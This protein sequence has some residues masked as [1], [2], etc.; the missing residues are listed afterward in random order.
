MVCQLSCYSQMR[1]LKWASLILLSPSRRTLQERTLFLAYFKSVSIFFSSS[2][3]PTEP[4]L[5]FALSSS[6]LLIVSSRATPPSFHMH[7]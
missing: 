3:L 2:L 7:G 4:P 6:Y 5:F 1:R